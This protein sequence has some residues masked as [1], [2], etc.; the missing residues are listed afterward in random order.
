MKN[1]TKLEQQAIEMMNTNSRGTQ[2][3]NNK[4]I[5]Y[6]LLTSTTVT[7]AMAPIKAATL[8][9]EKTKIEP[10]EKQYVD[11]VISIKNSLDTM[12]SNY[13]HVEKIERDKLLSGSVMETS[14]N[15]EISIVPGE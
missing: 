6:D 12:V 8:Y 14:T 10:T 9:Y 7:R 3:I 4:T 11:K 1:L 13:N 5:L 2:S 15:G